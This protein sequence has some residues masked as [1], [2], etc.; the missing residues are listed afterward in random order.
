MQNIRLEYGVDATLMEMSGLQHIS[1]N[2]TG[3]KLVLLY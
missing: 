2:R 3:E 1:S